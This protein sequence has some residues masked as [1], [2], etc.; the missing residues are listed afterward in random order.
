MSSRGRSNRSRGPGLDDFPGSGDRRDAQSRF[1]ARSRSTSLSS[2]SDAGSPTSKDRG[3]NGFSRPDSL[4]VDHRTLMGKA[5]SAPSMSVM[6]SVPDASGYTTPRHPTGGVLPFASPDGRSNGTAADRDRAESYSA[7]SRVNGIAG[8][9]ASGHASAAAAD[10]PSKGAIRRGFKRMLQ[11]VP[12]PSHFRRSM[13]F[14][15]SLSAI[16][17]AA[18]R[19][20]TGAMTPIRR[21]RH[22]RE[23]SR[24][25]NE[26]TGGTFGPETSWSASRDDAATAAAAGSCETPASRRSGRIGRSVGRSRLRS[27]SNPGSSSAAEGDA[28]LLPGGKKHRRGKT[29]PGG[30][31]GVRGLVEQ[32]GLD[33]GK[34]ASAQ[35]PSSP[36][37][38]PPAGESGS[39]GLR[40]GLSGKR[41]S[42]RT[43]ERVSSFA[44]KRDKSS[45]GREPL[46]AQLPAQSNAGKASPSPTRAAEAAEEEEKA[47]MGAEKAPLDEG[48]H[49]ASALS[50]AD[51]T[52][53]FGTIS[54]A[55]NA[56]LSAGFDGRSGTRTAADANRA[57]VSVGGPAIAEDESVVGGGGDVDAGTQEQKR[58]HQRHGSGE[59]GGGADSSSASSSTA[60]S[61]IGGGIVRRD[62]DGGRPPSHDVRKVRIRQSSSFAAASSAEARDSAPHHPRESPRPPAAPAAAGRGITISV[63]S[64]RSSDISG[65]FP[66]KQRPPLSLTS[67]DNLSGGSG[68]TAVAAAGK[69]SRPLI[70]RGRSFF[71]TTGSGGATQMFASSPNGARA[72]ARRARS[73]HRMSG[74]ASSVWSSSPRE[75]AAGNQRQDPIVKSQAAGGA[76]RTEEAGS[77]GREGGAADGEGDAGDAALSGAERSAGAAVGDA[78]GG[79]GTEAK[80]GG[81]AEAAVEG[82]RG[83]ATGGDAAAAAAASPKGGTGIIR[84]GERLPAAPASQEASSSRKL[85][86]HRSNSSGSMVNGRRSPV[87][88]SYVPPAP[89]PPLLSGGASGRGFGRSRGGVRA[90]SPISSD[91][92]NDSEASSGGTG[93]LSPELMHAR[94]SLKRV[95]SSGQRGVAGAAAAEREARSGKANWVAETAAGSNARRSAQCSSSV[96]FSSSSSSSNGGGGGGGG[97]DGAEP[98]GGKLDGSGRT[99]P[100]LSNSDEDDVSGDSNH[101]KEG[102]RKARQA[103]SQ[104]L[105]LEERRAALIAASRRASSGP[106]PP[107]PRLLSQASWE[108]GGGSGGD[109][110]EA[111]PIRPT[112]KKSLARSKTSV[113][114]GST[115]FSRQADRVAAAAAFLRGRHSGSFDDA[116]SVVVPLQAEMG[117]RRKQEQLSQEQRPSQEGDEE[118]TAM[119]AV[120][121][122]AAALASR[123]KTPKQQKVGTSSSPVSTSSLSSS[124]PPVQQQP[125]FEN[126]PGAGASAAQLAPAAPAVDEASIAEEGGSASSPCASSN[127]SGS[128]GRDGTGSVASSASGTS[129]GSKTR[130]SSRTSSRASKDG[131]GVDSPRHNGSG[132]GGGVRSLVP[133]PRLVPSMIFDVEPRKPA[134]QGEGGSAAAAGI[135]KPGGQNADGDGGG[136]D[137]ALAAEEVATPTKQGGGEV[138]DG[139]STQGQTDDAPP[140]EM[141]ALGVLLV[142]SMCGTM[143][144]EK[145]DAFR[146]GTTGVEAKEGVSRA[147]DGGRAGRG[148]GDGK[149]EA[150]VEVTRCSRCRKGCCEAC[151]KQLPVHCRGPNVVAPVCRSCFR[152]VDF[153]NRWHDHLIA[154]SRQRG[155]H[156]LPNEE[157]ARRRGSGAASPGADSACGS[158]GDSPLRT[159]P[160]GAGG[161]SWGNAGARTGGR[162]TT[163]A[164]AAVKAARSAEQKPSPSASLLRAS[165]RLFRRSLSTSG[166][167]DTGKPALPSAGLRNGGGDSGQTT[168]RGKGSPA[169]AAVAPPLELFKTVPMPMPLGGESG[170]P[171]SMPRSKSQRERSLTET[172]GSATS[173]AAASS[174]TT[175]ML[176]TSTMSWFGSSIGSAFSSLGGYAGGT[177]GGGG[178]GTACTSSGIPRLTSGVSPK[179][180][181]EALMATPPSAGLTPASPDSP[182]PSSFALMERHADSRPVSG[183]TAAAAAAPT[184]RTPWATARA[185]MTTIVGDAGGAASSGGADDGG[186]GSGSA[187]GKARVAPG[188]GRWSPVKHHHASRSG[189][190]PTECPCGAA[191]LY[192]EVI[193]MG[194]Q[195]VTMTAATV[196]AGGEAVGAAEA[197]AELEA[198]AEAAHKMLR[199][200]AYA[201][202]LTRATKALAYARLQGEAFAFLRERGVAAKSEEALLSFKSKAARMSREHHPRPLPPLGALGDL[203]SPSAEF[204][205]AMAAPAP[206]PPQSS[207]PVR[208]A[209][210]AGKAVGDAASSDSSGVGSGVGGSRMGSST[211]SGGEK[212]RSPAAA[213]WILT[214]SATGGGG[215]VGSV[216]NGGS[217]STTRVAGGG[218]GGAL[219]MAGSLGLDSLSPRAPLFSAASAVASPA[220]AAGTVAKTTAGEVSARLAVARATAV[221]SGAPPPLPLPEPT[222][223]QATAPLFTKVAAFGGVTSSETPSPIRLL[224]SRE[225]AVEAAVGAVRKAPGA[226]VE[227]G[228]K[229]E[230]ES[231]RRRESHVDKEKEQKEEQ[232]EKQE[233]EQEESSA[234]AWVR[235]ERRKMDQMVDSLRRAR[236][237]NARKAASDEQQPRQQPQQQPQPR[238]RRRRFS[239]GGDDDYDDDYDDDDEVFT[240]GEEGDGDDHASVADSAARRDSL[241]SLR[242]GVSSRRDGGSG[243]SYGSRRAGGSGRSSRDGSEHGLSSGTNGSREN[244]VS[245]SEDGRPGRRRSR[246]K[247]SGEV[248]GGRRRRG[249]SGSSDGRSGGRKTGRREGSSNVYGGGERSK[250]RG[251][252]RPHQKQQQQQQQQEEQHPH[253]STKGRG[254]AGR[255]TKAR[256]VEKPRR[257]GRRAPGAL[258]SGS[259]T[260]NS[261]HSDSRSPAG[262]GAALDDVEDDEDDL[263]SSFSPLGVP[264]SSAVIGSLA[265]EMAVR[266]LGGGSGGWRGGKR[267][268]GAMAAPPLTFGDATAEEMVKLIKD[269][270]VLFEN[271][272]SGPG[273]AATKF[274]RRGKPRRIVLTLVLPKGGVGSG[275]SGSSSSVGTSWSGISPASSAGGGS[276]GRSQHEPAELPMRP[277]PSSFRRRGVATLAR[278]TSNLFEA[279]AGGGGG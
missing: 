71:G 158:P 137:S 202:L 233:E 12:S 145:N 249:R 160:F 135:E 39:G 113:D 43:R 228:G 219:P 30:A 130:G 79:R 205:T 185:P 58:T 164:A 62:E 186:S 73:L 253:H 140:A 29:E 139:Q 50:S 101:R 72:A 147:E 199:A 215:G 251:Q 163:I 157:G 66:P 90:W 270:E 38:S 36:R 213:T 85:L 17:N 267:A 246:S 53:N 259:G 144:K 235:S 193:E 34:R 176:S 260:S 138:V 91:A 209:E 168:V 16:S 61:A 119:A 97:E 212:N 94:A 271:M 22:R 220:P 103:G 56:M 172:E 240:S 180:P 112:P 63:P 26:G 21:R 170:R 80:E 45:R 95:S 238:R 128:S 152:G 14:Q 206:S 216:D 104:S 3:R 116:P 114:D 190:D 60:R 189:R 236:D 127:S 106:P 250:R 222:A 162:S 67:D 129:R 221:A 257:S 192:R 25:S 154:T 204:T 225:R 210:A 273:I 92:A 191:A 107:P 265:A 268:R 28:V 217:P 149:A 264:A 223:K 75:N 124:T 183:E 87:P 51:G 279:A 82:A 133:G 208:P 242:D 121:A 181:E 245:G 274:P 275:G 49:S 109:K 174:G 69:G 11:G 277:S 173:T 115:T 102:G 169:A 214:H 262:G 70:A 123:S 86:V 19:V 108:V 76:G 141:G 196:V 83:A 232:K 48:R 9:T 117:A 261:H 151:F 136:G 263:A 203:P 32:A 194:G 179:G 171:L 59:G 20:A 258:S 266:G 218:G 13:S 165:T 256:T 68:G 47:A 182:T 65:S 272:I 35:A 57:G 126:R 198:K 89:T 46:S 237:F 187:T 269:R 88:L 188:E 278:A 134:P 41:S 120:A 234:V 148:D 44:R 7:G 248:G 5:A 93:F 78:A 252:E 143:E 255:G 74:S 247:D 33:V 254:S 200:K 122:A 207:A 23:N 110:G 24:D 54:T 132:N 8:G 125:L 159:S 131:D 64:P 2:L 84:H 241:L 178:G 201:H 226:P 161:G 118:A 6:R 211:D 40:R 96:S 276:D 55:P 99:S 15:G 81:A 166:V 1:R 244:R 231:A 175:S 4:S 31:E 167:L 37:A 18:N 155:R 142:C 77:A 111:G 184:A 227:R 243:S 156:L 150:E 229:E 146:D 98:S 195:G 153:E 10:D 239:A 105:K 177:V 42:F 197:A 27:G 52:V 100:D 230:Q 224:R